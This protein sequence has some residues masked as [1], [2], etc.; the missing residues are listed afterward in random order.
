MELT[1]DRRHK[2]NA[3]TSR[4]APSECRDQFRSR[5]RARTMTTFSTLEP[6]TV[7]A[8]PGR[9]SQ[10]VQRPP[11]DAHPARQPSI[12]A[13]A[14]DARARRS[15]APPSRRVSV[16][17]L[18]RDAPTLNGTLPVPDAA[19]FPEES[20]SP[21]SVLPMLFLP[22]PVSS[23]PLALRRLPTSPQTRAACAPVAQS[24]RRV[25]ASPQPPALG[26]G[27]VSGPGHPQPEV[28]P[29]GPRK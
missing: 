5:P 15:R 1:C 4:S 12:T 22:V 3:L 14:P 18:A 11:R 13:G 20:S 6:T 27:P 24:H 2:Q 8:R 25:A 23:G 26:T 29:R 17:I 10:S 21:L 9:P 28:K 16:E 7:A 19:A